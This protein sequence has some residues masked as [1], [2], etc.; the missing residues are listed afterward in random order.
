VD[1]IYYCPHHPDDGC[2][3]RKPNID[4]GVRAI[5]GHNINPKTSFMVGNS[6][7]DMEFGRKIGL[8]TI[9]VS[10][11]R[12]FADAVDEILGTLE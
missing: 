11:D 2:S 9:Q 4:M 8:R 1:A 3:C 5:M 12:S 10:N 7:G 6:N